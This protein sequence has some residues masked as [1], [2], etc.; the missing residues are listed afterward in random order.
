MARAVHLTDLREALNAVY[1]AL[2]RARPTYTDLT[3]VP[4]Q[5]VIMKTQIEQLRSAVIAAEQ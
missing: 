1:D 2:G 4:G 3:I 5:T